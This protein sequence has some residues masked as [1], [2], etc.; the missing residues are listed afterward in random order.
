MQ[1]E[2]MVGQ[3][4]I[5]GAVEAMLFA[6]GGPLTMDEIRKIF[7]R[8]WKDEPEDDLETRRDIL[9]SA[10]TELTDSWGD[11]ATNRGFVLV[12]VA[13]GLTFRT[14]PRFGDALRAMR[15]QRPV[16]LS[17][18]ALE[19]LAIVAYR[20]PVTKPELDHIRGVD[21]GGTLRLLLDRSLVK[22]VGKREE[23][24]RPLLY[25]TTK[26]FLSFFSLSNLAQLPT[27][28]EYH[29]L[30]EDSRD[31]L[32]EFDGVSLEDL[33]ESAQQLNLDEDGAAV[34]LDEAVATLEQTEESTRSALERKGIKLHPNP[35]L[36]PGAPT[37]DVDAPAGERSSSES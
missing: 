23:P 3:D 25:G 24:G 26:E 14:N 2:G 8:L 27:L 15:E 28:R 4:D 37:P 33:A 29:E 18:A 30:S 5:R 6:A 10:I 20:Q 1:V 35:N 22:I 21:C 32:A 11:E 17:R 36:H 12:K 34:S 9:K 31:E 7:D 16:R 13:E 19:A